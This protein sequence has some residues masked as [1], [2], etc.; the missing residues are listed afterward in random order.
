M[1]MIICIMLLR[2]EYSNHVR[3]ELQLRQEVRKEEG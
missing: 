1:P 2:K 3:K